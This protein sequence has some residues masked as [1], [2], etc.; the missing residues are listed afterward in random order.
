MQCNIKLISGSGELL[1]REDNIFL[2]HFST[3]IYNIS[4]KID[5]KFLKRL[6][7]GN[8]MLLIATPIKEDT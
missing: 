5:G 6:H 4:D 7:I 8:D 2:T 3:N 1:L